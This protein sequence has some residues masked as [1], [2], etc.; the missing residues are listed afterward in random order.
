[1]GFLRKGR[2]SAGGKHFSGWF[3]C[4]SMFAHTVHVAI[5]PGPR[6]LSTSGPALTRTNREVQQKNKQKKGVAMV[7]SLEV[8]ASGYSDRE[9]Q[10]KTKNKKRCSNGCVETLEVGASG[11]WTSRTATWRMRK[12]GGRHSETM[13]IQCVKEGTSQAT[14]L[15]TQPGPNTYRHNR[16]PW[17]LFED[18]PLKLEQCREA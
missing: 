16:T 15:Q 12:C 10:Q 8:G 7:A 4:G 14:N 3:P 1:M 11:S 2:L 6:Y 9:V 17:I 5:W 13:K 18:H